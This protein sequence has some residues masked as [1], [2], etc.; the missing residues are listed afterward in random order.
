M[1]NYNEY[2]SREPDYENIYKKHLKQI[3][4][5]FPKPYKFKERIS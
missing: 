3:H 4:E 2:K 5:D 1:Q